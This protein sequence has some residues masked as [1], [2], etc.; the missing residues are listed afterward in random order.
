MDN[1]FLAYLKL[2]SATEEDSPQK[3]R[4]AVRKVSDRETEQ[5]LFEDSPQQFN[6]GFSEEK[7][8]EDK[9]RAARELIE[10]SKEDIYYREASNAESLE[11]PNRRNKVIIDKE[12]DQRRFEDAEYKGIGGSGDRIEKHS[13]I[14]YGNN[15]GNFDEFSNLIG[16]NINS[17]DKYNK[18]I[19]EDKYAKQ[20]E[21]RRL[22]DQQRMKSKEITRLE[23]TKY[24]Y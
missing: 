4:L 6:I 24:G 15:N 8:R 17:E 12:L 11:N 2:M 14:M 23:S 19:V 1:Y 20:A 7:L 10:R 21:Y 5:R 16:M 18:N 3:Y 13:K 22:L 9:R